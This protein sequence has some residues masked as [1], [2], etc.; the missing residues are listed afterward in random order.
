VL[1][2]YAIRVFT[3]VEHSLRFEAEETKKSIFI[4]RAGTAETKD[5]D[6]IIST[7]DDSSRD[8]IEQDYD[9]I[10]KLKGLL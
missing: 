5:L 6:K 9:S 7:L 10:D 1:D 8:I 4:A 3:L 2:E